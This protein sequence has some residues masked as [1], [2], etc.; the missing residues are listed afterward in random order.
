MSPCGV[1]CPRAPCAAGLRTEPRAGLRL[2]LAAGADSAASLAGYKA[3]WRSVPR[4]RYGCCGRKK[5]ARAGHRRI[6][7]WPR[8]QRPA[9][10]LSKEL[11]PMPLSPRSSSASPGRSVKERSWMMKGGGRSLIASSVAPQLGP[12]LAGAQRDRWSTSSSLDLLVGSPWDSGSSCCSTSD[13]AGRWARLSP[14]IERPEL[15]CEATARAETSASAAASDASAMAFCRARTRCASAPR[16]EI[17]S[18]SE[19]RNV[20]LSRTLPNA[21]PV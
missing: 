15:S 20:R 19:M 5:Q 11:F 9:I 21:K 18:N 7:P 2:L 1:S 3:C 12:G 13:K 6:K 17:T 14:L 16:L 4:Q 10:A 8:V